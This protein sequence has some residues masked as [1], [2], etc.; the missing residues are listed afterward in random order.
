MPP[1]SP[2]YVRRNADDELFDSLMEREFC[3]VLTP[4]QMGKSSLMARTAKRLQ[5]NDARTAV[6]DLT[7][8]GG[9]KENVTAAQWYYG[10]MYHLLRGLQVS[11]E[12]EGWW[13]RKEN[14]PPLQRLSD[15]FGEVLLTLI[16]K[17]IV[18]FVDEID[19]TIGLPFADDFFAALRAVYNARALDPTYKRLTFVLLGVASPAELIRD[20]RRTPFNIGRPIELRDFTASEARVL[21]D[22]LSHGTRN[23]EAILERIMYWTAGH[24]YL[25]QKLCR[26]VAEEMREGLDG[27]D[28]VD[29]VVDR[30]FLNPQSVRTEENLKFV[31]ARLKQDSASKALLRLLT[32]IRHGM[33]VVS[34]PTSRLHSAL[35]LSGVVV[36]G[37]TGN[38]AVRNQI[39]DQVFTAKW[40]RTDRKLGAVWARRSLRY[41]AAGQ[42]DHALLCRLRALEFEP[43]EEHRREATHLAEGDL[44][45]LRATLRH[46][47][48][49]TAVAWSPDGRTILTASEDGTAQLWDAFTGE[50]KGGS[51]RHRGPVLAAA[52]SP[53]GNVVA[54]ASRDST[55]RLWS[56]DTGAPIGPPL[57]HKKP[58]WL[59]LFNPRGDLLLTS[60]EDRTARLWNVATGEPFGPVFEHDGAVETAAFTPD[61]VRIVTVTDRNELRLWDVQTGSELGSLV[62]ADGRI[63]VVTFRPDGRTLLTA[64]DHRVAVLWDVDPSADPCIRRVFLGQT[65]GTLYLRGAHHESWIRAACFSSDGKVILTGSEDKTARFWESSSG[66]PRGR[67]LRHEN[68]VRTVA[69]SP[70]GQIAATGGEDNVACVW[71]LPSGAPLTPKLR[72]EARV[73]AASFSPDGRVLATASH[74]GSTRIW[75]LDSVKQNA[76][77]PVVSHDAVVSAVAFSADGRLMATGSEDRTAKVWN[78]DRAMPVCGPLQHSG[79]V[80]IVAF[81]PRRNLLLTASDDNNA[82]LWNSETGEPETFFLHHDSE[83]NTAAFSEDGSLVATGSADTT[84]RIWNARSGEPLAG[85]MEHESAVADVRFSP[86]GNFLVT[87][88]DRN[89]TRVWSVET[90]KQLFNL[91]H[92]GTTHAIAFAP[93]EGAIATGSDD[94]TAMLWSLQTGLPL[95]MPLRHRSGV[96]SLAFSPDG[97][98]LATGD[99]RSLCLWRA[100][101]GAPLGKPLHLSEPVRF[102]VFSPD[103]KFIFCATDSWIHVYTTKG[104]AIASRLLPGICTGA[105][106]FLRSGGT[107]IR[108]AVRRTP[109]TIVP[110]DIDLDHLLTP[111]EGDPGMLRET[112]STRLALKIDEQDH[113]ISRWPLERKRRAGIYS[114]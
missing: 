24:P 88:S 13:K 22:G 64:G 69:L 15:F 77:A 98:I 49:L 67:L 112:W 40:A 55:G 79:A 60:G 9:V 114:P 30:Y 5:V 59:A 94:N 97:R 42:R 106:R 37:P 103:G 50:P 6:V 36:S 2:S 43:V 102:V 109:D 1:D 25:T 46:R 51:L 81:A 39:Y 23:H 44:A 18:I 14:L 11:F 92:D 91:S 62:K 105:K 29:G 107:V 4:R 101:F 80:R 61:G 76:G 113:V 12:L 87:S 111:I 56:A 68:W 48:P 16:P 95:S 53:L 108:V 10:F 54:T 110:V 26:A 96:R 71:A 21:I 72:H 32:R 75:A 78:A 86:D 3:Y 47:G 7:G 19:T 45:M 27:L 82:L 63:T 89:I 58:V 66:A 104:T 84:A 28:F 100:D 83:I 70:D 33:A 65:D 99:D 85:A 57:R 20:V 93:G 90:R 34:D 35:K 38:L 41:A 17:P 31:A 74:D 73:V 8:I 52:F